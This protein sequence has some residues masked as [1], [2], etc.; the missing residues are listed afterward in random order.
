[1][2]PV[3]GSTLLCD[4]EPD[5]CPLW[6]PVSQCLERGLDEIVLEASFSLCC[7]Y[8]DIPDTAWYNWG[9]DVCLMYSFRFYRE[10]ESVG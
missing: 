7:F 10:T 8:C 1:M 4:P 2:F 6:A 5:T 3:L 9:H